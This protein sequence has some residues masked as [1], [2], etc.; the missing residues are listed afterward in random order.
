MILNNDFIIKV[1]NLTKVYHL[2]DK[3]FDRVKEALSPLKKRYSRDFY[4]LNDIS[5]SIKKGE[6]VGIIG[7]NGA[8]KSTI[9]KIITGVLTPTQGSINVRGTIASLLELGAGF[10]PEM[11]GIENV[12]M[13]GIIMGYTRKE[14]GKKLDAIVDFADIGDFINQPVKMYS[15]GMFAR[16]AFSVNVNINPDVLIV[17]EALSVGDSFFQ[18][19]CLYR[20]KQMQEAGTT[21]LFVSHDIGAVKALCSRCIYLKNGRLIAD[22]AADEVCDMYQNHTTDLLKSASFTDRKSHT[23]I[24]KEKSGLKYFREDPDFGT[25]M[26]ERSGGGELR[27]TAFDLYYG[28]KMVTTQKMLTPL[29]IFVSGLT[30]KEIPDGTAVGVLCRDR[31]GN[32]IFAGNLNF[33]DI[34]LPQMKINEKFVMDITFD[35]PLA[36]GEYFF[37]IGAKPHPFSNYFYDRGF[38]IAK[39]TIEQPENIKDPVGGILFAKL[40]KFKLYQI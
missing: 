37:G 19:K 16:L 14:M 22:G 31:I 40:D 38:N 7:K 29:H 18:Q 24:S 35:V 25:R 26:T 3:K 12:Y 36:P 5:F 4:A 39:I 20:M 13:N 21:V 34:Y 32:D 15:S 9:L 1:Q 30:Y 11:T 10:N 2:F 6:T 33:H 27:F 23:I 8:G 28:D 17:D